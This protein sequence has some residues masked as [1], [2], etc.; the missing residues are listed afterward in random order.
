[1]ALLVETDNVLPVVP[2]V[3]ARASSSQEMF[4]EALSPPSVG[5]V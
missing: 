3:Y 5:K 2:A 4:A 1:M